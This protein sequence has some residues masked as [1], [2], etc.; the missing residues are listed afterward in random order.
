MNIYAKMHD[1]ALLAQFRYERT[2]QSIRSGETE[3]RMKAENEQKIIMVAYLEAQYKE[4]EAAFEAWKI[5]L[6]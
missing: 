2:L 3:A 4:A 6:P 5:S 1:S